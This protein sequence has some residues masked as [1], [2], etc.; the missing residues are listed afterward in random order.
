MYIPLLLARVIVPELVRVPASVPPVQ[1]I[2]FWLVNEPTIVP[3]L[4]WKSGKSRVAPP[5]PAVRVP[6]LNADTAVVP[7]E[8]DPDM[9][10]FPLT[11]KLPSI[12]APAVTV[13]EP[14]VRESAALRPL[15][16]LL[17]DWFPESMVTVRAA[18]GLMTTS[19][20]GPGTLPVLQ[21]EATFQLPL[22]DAIH[23]T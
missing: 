15:V 2:E 13:S 14:A 20:P 22:E 3:P 4:H 7:P 16:M 12:S 11:W 1:V 8:N 19:S 17:T 10:T 23:L 21:L 9:A 6:L 5:E 18:E